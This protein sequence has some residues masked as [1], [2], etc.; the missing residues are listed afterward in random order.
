M[1][2]LTQARILAQIGFGLVEM[3]ISTNPKPTIYRDLCENTG[4][5]RQDTVMSVRRQVSAPVLF[6]TF[7]CVWNQTI[8]RYINYL[9]DV[10]CALLVII[11]H[12]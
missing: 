4:L 7:R 2:D 5:R 9:Y 8:S 11:R 12:Y 1:F 6:Y 3:A 10:L